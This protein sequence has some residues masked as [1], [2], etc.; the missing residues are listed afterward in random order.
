MS[1][2]KGGL[3][4]SATSTGGGSVWRDGSG[5]PSDATGSNGDY[6][7]DTD[8]GDVYEKASGTYSV[9]ANL[10]GPTGPAGATGST[11]ATGATGPT[12]PTGP[13]GADGSDGDDIVDAVDGGAGYA[14]AAASVTLD[15]SSGRV[16]LL[17]VVTDIT[18]ITFTNMPDENTNATVVTLVLR[19]D[20]TGG[21]TIAEPTGSLEYRDGSEWTDLDTTANAKNVVV[22]ER[23]GSVWHT[24][25]DN[26]ITP[27]LGALAHQFDTD[28]TS[29]FV[30]WTDMSFDTDSAV[31]DGTGSVTFEKNGASDSGVITLASGD[32]LGIVATGVTA[33]FT[34]S[35]PRTA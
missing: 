29:V 32:T 20:G 17:D 9:V 7:L 30:A 15:L 4:Q 25:I 22:F 27:D 35:I 23:I 13:A 28:D 18:D 10:E 19:Q 1:L 6:Y 26:G 3:T 12:G 21:H 24:Y 33:P 2:L 34:V 14:N 8:S 16:F 11:G 31:T 5:A